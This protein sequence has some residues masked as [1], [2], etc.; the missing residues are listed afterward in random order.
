MLRY[1]VYT[2]S[3]PRNGEIFYVGKGCG[4][5]VL[6]HERQAKRGIQSPKCDRIREILASGNEVC[7]AKVGLFSAERDAYAFEAEL[8]ALLPGLT[9]GGRVGY[10]DLL[11]LRAFIGIL[12]A[13]QRVIED[14]ARPWASALSRAVADRADE[15]LALLSIR[16]NAIPAGTIRQ[17]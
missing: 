5:R 10:V 4:N 11:P 8:I 17:S 14:P 9:N 13:K 3:D 16:I 2:L 15:L 12:S 7:R 6:E 1:Y